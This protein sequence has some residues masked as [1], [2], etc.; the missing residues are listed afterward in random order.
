MTTN[1]TV[2]QIAEAAAAWLGFEKVIDP[3]IKESD[4]GDSEY[5]EYWHR[6]KQPGVKKLMKAKDWKPWEDRNQVQLLIETASQGDRIFYNRFLDKLVD[7]PVCPSALMAVDR[8][9]TTSCYQLLR[10]WHAVYV[11]QKEA[12]GGQG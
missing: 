6:W 11:E 1:P 8:A 7:Y 4:R 5:G 3:W 9:I 12:P 10:A 2:E